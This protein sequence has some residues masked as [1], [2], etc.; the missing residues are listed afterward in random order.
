MED[1]LQAS[2]QAIKGGRAYLLK[3]KSISKE[4]VEFAGP[5]FLK[6]ANGTKVSVYVAVDIKGAF[7]VQ[8]HEV[9]LGSV[10]KNKAPRKRHV[11]IQNECAASL[12]IESIDYDKKY[13][14]VENVWEKRGQKMFL[15]VSPN[16]ETIPSGAFT[17]Y[18]TIRASGEQF[19]VRLSGNVVN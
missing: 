2:L 1:Y 5:M 3:L 7:W 13:L 8:P 14:K 15:E 9:Y 12:F 10:S 4:A 19:K 18:L 6:L 11:M 16:L 17:K